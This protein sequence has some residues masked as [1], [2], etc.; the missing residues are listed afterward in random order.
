VITATDQLDHTSETTVPFSID[1]VAPVPVITEAPPALSTDPQPSFSF[2][3]PEAMAFSCAIDGEAPLPCSSPFEVED[4]LLD[5]SHSFE[6]LAT[7]LAGNTGR[8]VVSFVVDATAPQTFIS[9]HPRKFIRA[10]K[11]GIVGV[12]RFRSNESN[13]VLA[14]KID[15]GLWHFCRTRIRRRFKP[16]RHTITVKAQDEAGNV[17]PTP[18]VYRFVVRHRR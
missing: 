12:L 4:P 17:D 8:A 3:A 14:C 10:S 11:R 9:S 15:R 5:G 2:S 16:G 1:T 6:V 13:V 7:D 18:A